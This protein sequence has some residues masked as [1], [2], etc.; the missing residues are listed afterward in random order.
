MLTKQRMAIACMFIAMAIAGAYWKFGRRAHAENWPPEVHATILKVCLESF[1][2]VADEN[3]KRIDP[4]AYCMCLT[5]S[6]RQQGGTSL[7]ALSKAKSNDEFH[8][9][10]SDFLNGADGAEAKLDCFEHAGGR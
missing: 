1:K 9:L 10:F 5:E 4:T 7:A 8:S 3:F 2:Q 6:L